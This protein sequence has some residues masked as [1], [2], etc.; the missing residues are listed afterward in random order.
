MTTPSVAL[1]G[2]LGHGLWH[3]RAM[4]RLAGEGRIRI[5]GLSA[6]R[7]IGGT[8]DAPVDGIPT[9]TDYQVMLAETRPDVVIICTPPHT[10]LAMARDVFA[11]GADLLLEKPPVPTIEQHDLLQRAIEESG[12]HC[13][14]N[15]QALG[16][17]ALTEICE[18]VA[19]KDL[20]T[21]ASVDA[22]GAWWRPDTY[23]TRSAWAGKRTLDGNPIMDGALVNPFAHA[24]MQA[25]AVADAAGVTTLPMTLEL[26]RY[27][28]RDIEVDDV[29]CLRITFA[30]GCSTMV[31]VTLASLTFAAGEIITT[32]SEGTAL[33]EYPKDR[34]ILPGQAKWSEPRGRVGLLENLLDHR[35][36]PAV[37]LLAPLSRTARFTMIAE[38]VVAAPLPGRIDDRFLSPN[39]DGTGNVVDGI[40]ELMRRVVRERTLPSELS[41]PW[42]TT[43]HRVVCDRRE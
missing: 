35:A 25:L 36:D 10:H 24:V 42:A 3:R 1:I 30:S 28:S 11:T 2:A 34:V 4:H 20:G 23:F 18:L 33:L 13:Q 15:F 43:P 8:E 31:A 9:F 32:G 38:A 17:T 27:R 12:R 22:V 41:V 19:G 6:R 29:A 40:E 16:S 7:P 14:I 21:I 37:P 39:P 26:E 5:A